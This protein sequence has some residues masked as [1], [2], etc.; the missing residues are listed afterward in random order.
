MCI[1]GGKKEIV[2]KGGNIGESEER[3]EEVLVDA[4]CEC[5]L[6]Q[7]METHNAFELPQFMD[8]KYHSKWR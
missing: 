8:E 6:I 1:I 2:A 7:R 4:W 5:A 3:D